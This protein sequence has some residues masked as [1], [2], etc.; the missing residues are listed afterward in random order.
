MISL[1]FNHKVT[2]FPSGLTLQYP[3]SPCRRRRV[4]FSWDSWNLRRASWPEW[5]VLRPGIRIEK[6]DFTINSVISSDTGQGNDA[7]RT[8]RALCFRPNEPKN[9]KE[10]ERVPEGCCVCLSQEPLCVSYALSLSSLSADSLA[11]VRVRAH[12]RKAAALSLSV[13]ALSLSPSLGRPSLSLRACVRVRKRR[14]GGERTDLTV[15]RLQPRLWAFSLS[16]HEAGLGL[17]VLHRTKTCER[18]QGTG[19]ADNHKKCE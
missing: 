14:A 4:L 17:P 8:E 6:L 19:A 9:K 16:L 1:R 18:A 15:T 3:Q 2:T 13:C 5:S 12:E 11:S 10:P 7:P